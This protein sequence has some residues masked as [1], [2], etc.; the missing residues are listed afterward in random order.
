MALTG[1]NY[2]MKVSIADAV[3]VNGGKVL[4]VQQRKQS[5]YAL[6]SFPGGHVE[7]GETPEQAIHREVEEELGANLINAKPFK[8][9][10]LKTPTGELKLNTFTGTIEG[11]I[12]LKNDE[13]MAYDWFSLGSLEHMQDKLRAPVIFEQACDVLRAEQPLGQNWGEL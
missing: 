13:L 9:Y 4:L 3:I 8:I 5:A 11:N 12:T 7:A 6:W 10:T 2:R 1:A